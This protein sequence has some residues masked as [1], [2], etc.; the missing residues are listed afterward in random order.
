MRVAGLAQRTTAE[1][2]AIFEMLDVPAARYN[3]IDDLFVDPH[4]A[5]IGFFEREEHPSEGPIRRTKVANTFHG[6]MREDRMPA[7]RLGE[8]TRA[9]LA[10][11]G[12]SAA[13]IAGMIASGA[14]R[15]G[16]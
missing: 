12:Y 6:G 13:E 15:E 8:H 9:V 7:P 16:D 4:L 5:D 14:V 1:W 3:S 2:L 10:G 11:V